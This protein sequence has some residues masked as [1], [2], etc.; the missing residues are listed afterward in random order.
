MVRIVDRYL[1]KALSGAFLLG[2]LILLFLMLAHQCMRLADLLMGQGMDLATL[3]RVF[4]LLLP[5]LFLRTIPMAVMLASVVTFHRLTLDR[6]IVA[7]QSAGISLLRMSRPAF[8]FSLCAAMLTLL[9]AYGTR[10]TEGHSL[11]SRALG[12]IKTQVG[13]LGLSPGKFIEK[14]GRVV[15]VE[16]MPTPTD[17]SGVFI[18]DPQSDGPLLILARAGRIARAPSS[19]VVNLLLL[20]GSLHR[21]GKGAADHQQIAFS[22]Y[23]L[24]L[25]LA[26]NP[27]DPVAPAPNATQPRT[28]NAGEETAQTLHDPAAFYKNFSLVATTF[29]F[30]MIGVPLGLLA[31]RAGRLSGVAAGIGLIL[32]YYLLTLLGDHFVAQRWL[33]PWVAA[34]LPH[35]ILAPVGLILFALA[36]REPLPPFL[37]W[38]G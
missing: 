20:D 11:K 18:Y 32:F 9:A 23:A 2:L 16:S 17:L 7:L 19:D 35:A 30:G 34:A 10:S 29:L 27:L 8:A 12:L 24:T 21:R 13:L 1:F 37:S 28:Q 3:V 36:H 4:L 31:G 38:R 25:G 5:P 26:S 6:E 15:Y 22:T 33:S 14:G